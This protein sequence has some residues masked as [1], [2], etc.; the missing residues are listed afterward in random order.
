[1]AYF[2]S[3]AGLHR[4]EQMI[5]PRLL[6]VFDFDGTLAPIVAH[7]EQASLPREVRS[8]MLL[9]SE[10]TTVG[11][12]TGR[13]VSDVR[14]RLGFSP[15]YMMGNHG[16]EGVPGWEC[17]KESY[18]EINRQWEQQL[19]TMLQAQAQ[20]E[21]GIQIENKT[22]S[23][24][25]HYRLAHDPLASANKLLQMFDGLEPA[26]RIITGKCVF[27]LLPHGAADKGSALTQLMLATN[28][29]GAIYVG[30]DVT[31]EDVF[32]LQ[33]DDILSVRTEY[34]AGSAA[35]FFLTNQ[36]EMPRLLDELTCR[37]AH[38]LMH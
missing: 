2:F 31:D 32:L 26:P 7:P 22:F 10:V 27:N 28:A 20:L 4:L 9:L 6:C 3:E 15:H 21:P 38:S 14:S 35:E 16:I 11:I 29:Q 34:A 17:R 23:L 25:V 37:I 12:L 5:A 19:R 18:V 33:R 1:M 24:S 13:S 30:D 36:L 8:Q